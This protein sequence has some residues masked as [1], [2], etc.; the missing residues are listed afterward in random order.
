MKLLGGLDYTYAVRGDGQLVT[1]FVDPALQRG[2]LDALLLSIHANTLTLPEH[3][4][5]IIPPRTYG[6]SRH[7]ETFDIRTGVTLDPLAMAEMA[8]DMVV[9]LI[10]HPARAARLIEYH[11]RD[12]ALPSLD[13]VIAALID[14]TW[15]EKAPPGLF[16]EV[17]R[18]V[19]EV[20]LTNLMHLASSDAASPLVRASADRQL[21]QLAIYLGATLRRAESATAAQF[22]EAINRIR[23]FRE[24]PTAFS[25]PVAPDLPPGSPIGVQWDEFCAT[26]MP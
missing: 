21:E 17:H 22:T 1:G 26:N 8:A 6:S 7:R 4:L 19:S 15:K 11:A 3:I 25:F 18:T 2:A 9:S 24:D 10:L 16:G 23:R 20:V 14:P 12:D 13:E 5:R